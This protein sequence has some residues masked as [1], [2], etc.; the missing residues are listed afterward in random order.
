MAMKDWEKIDLG[1]IGNT[2]HLIK[3]N[4]KG[5][6]G[7]PRHEIE[8]YQVVDDVNWYVNIGEVGKRTFKTKTKA[9]QYAE[10]YMRNH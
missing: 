6:Y 10:S 1:S 9:L 5:K 8:L 7:I 2:R 3:W 4:R